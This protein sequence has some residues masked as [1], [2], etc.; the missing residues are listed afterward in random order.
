MTH[1][2][3]GGVHT[4]P[5]SSACGPPPLLGFD[6]SC[7][8]CSYMRAAHDVVGVGKGRRIGG[9]S[10]READTT[11]KRVRATPGGIQNAAYTSNCASATPSLAVGAH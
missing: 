7:Q 9:T 11:G 1:R 10:W 4:G 2:S 6:A 3:S 8:P 5:S